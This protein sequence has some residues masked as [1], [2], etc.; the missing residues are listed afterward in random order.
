MSN[1]ICF[2]DMEWMTTD[3]TGQTEGESPEGMTG[4]TEGEGPEGMIHLLHASI[5]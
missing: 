1:I 4:Q 3:R 5:I 2:V